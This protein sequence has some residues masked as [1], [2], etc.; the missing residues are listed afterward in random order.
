MLV[1]RDYANRSIRLT[2]ER[3]T[4][5][6]EHAEMAELYHAIPETLAR[7]Q[8]VVQSIAD[9]HAPLYY[10]RYPQTRVGEKYVCVVVKVV[11]RDAF[12]L[13]AYLTDS[14]K[15]GARIWPRST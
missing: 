11:D 4:H 14:I 15:R 2:D 9:R 13:T 6:L 12:V 8:R 10:R 1:L 7:P 5:I 3:L